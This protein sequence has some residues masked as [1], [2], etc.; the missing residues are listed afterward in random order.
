VLVSTKFLHHNSS[1]ILTIICNKVFEKKMN[2][3]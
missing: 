1:S 2:F 3:I